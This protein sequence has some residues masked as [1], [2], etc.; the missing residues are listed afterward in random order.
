MQARVQKRIP[1]GGGL[2][3]GSADAAAMLHGLNRLFELGLSSED[4]VVNTVDASISLR[5]RKE[6]SKKI[7]KLDYSLSSNN[8]ASDIDGEV[9]D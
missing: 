6:E 2:G 4:L 9:A 5:I 3:G 7:E 1:V 8:F